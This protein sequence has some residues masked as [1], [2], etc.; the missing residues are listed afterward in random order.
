[1]YPLVCKKKLSLQNKSIHKKQGE[2]LCFEGV[3]FLYI[4]YEPCFFESTVIIEI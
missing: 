2:P 1:M 3:Q 4:D